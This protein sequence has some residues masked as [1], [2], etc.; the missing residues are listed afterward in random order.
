MP[1][2]GSLRKLC[3][4]RDFLKLWLGRVISR[5]GDSVDA[6]A[7][8]WMIYQLT[9]STV[10]MGSIMAVNFTPNLL[11]GMFAGV[12]VDRW[13]KKTIMLLG[14]LGRGSVVALTAVLFMSG[15]LE[16]WQLF[17]FTVINSTL[18][19]FASPARTSTIPRLISD[20][21]D[22]ILAN[23]LSK[24]GSS[25]AELAGLG[26]A[27]LIIGLWGIAAALIIDAATFFICGAFVAWAAVPRIES[28]LEHKPLSLSSF[29]DD[30]SEGLRVTFGQPA[31]RL[32]VF[33]AVALNLVLSPF[34]VLAPVFA[35]NVMRLGAKGYS[36]MSLAITAGMMLGALLAGQLGQR[37]S[38]R[39]MI[40]AGLILLSSGFLTLWCLTHIVL[41]FLA[42]A[43]LGIGT[44]MISAAFT[45][46][47]MQTCPQDKMGR[48]ASIMNSAGMA[49]MPLS[50]AVAGLLAVHFAVQRL[51][52]GMA[53]LVGLI[54]VTVGLSSAW[55]NEKP[56]ELS[57]AV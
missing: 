43:A 46:L 4:Y 18:E 31:I 12:L 52:L 38:L 56:S 9:G 39:N 23:S 15:R 57:A 20:S 19:T 24:A 37:L 53:V 44:A 22:I 14:D 33:L 35:D 11:L 13:N 26:A 55:Q 27:G 29:K 3:R 47:F 30:F 51:F 49:A 21:N 42:S 10:L 5:F 45:T 50:T 25:L 17:V 32:C 41:A 16:I 8:M 28:E 54:A 7:Y 40:L 48:A 36:L 2:P 6:I 34:H 1:Q